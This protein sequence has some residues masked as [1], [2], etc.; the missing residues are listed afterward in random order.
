MSS[1]CWIIWLRPPNSPCTLHD[2]MFLLKVR[3][4]SPSLA[5]NCLLLLQLLYQSMSHPLSFHS[6]AK[7]IL[8]TAPFPNLSPLTKMQIPSDLHHFSLEELASH[9]MCAHPLLC[10]HWIL[11]KHHLLLMKNNNWLGTRWCL[12][13]HTPSKDRILLVCK[14][15]QTRVI[16]NVKL[17]H[18]FSNCL[19]MVAVTP[20]NKCIS[21]RLL[22]HP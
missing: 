19:I 4:S 17:Y 15:L 7:L 9:S 18:V 14:I 12:N 2:Q 10:V 13:T 1:T 22:K 6:S 21:K 16:I 5:H 20:M 11:I 3:Q 8:L